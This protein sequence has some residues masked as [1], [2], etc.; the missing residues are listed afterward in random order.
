MGRVVLSMLTSLDGH[1]NDSA[2]KVGAL[3]PD[4]AALQATTVMQDAWERGQRVTV[5]GLIYR[6]QDGLLRQLGFA[7]DSASG[8]R[9]AYAAA[10]TGIVNQPP[11]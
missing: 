6:L 5:H 2:G 1:V 4:L 11:L 3:Y 9:P 8:V 7:V 10:L